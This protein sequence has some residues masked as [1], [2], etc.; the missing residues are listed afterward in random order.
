MA[1]VVTVTGVRAMP[2]SGFAVQFGDFEV[3]FQGGF[4]QLNA[5]LADFK[6]LPTLRKI[7]LTVA[8]DKGINTGAGLIG[9]SMTYDPTLA[10]NVLVWG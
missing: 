1:A 3:E 10:A 7:L 8:N 5:T 2:G 6:T 9:H 4:A